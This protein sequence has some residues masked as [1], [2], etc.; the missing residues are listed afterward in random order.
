MLIDLRDRLAWPEPA[1]GAAA[2]LA[3]RGRDA[4]GRRCVVRRRLHRRGQDRARHPARGRRGRRV[5]QGTQRRHPGAAAVGCLRWAA[6]V[7]A[8]RP[9]PRRGQ[10]VPAAAGVE[11]GLRDRRPSGA[12][13]AHAATTRCAPPATRRPCSST[14]ARAAGARTGPRVRCSAWCRRRVHASTRAG[15]SPA[16]PCC[17]TPTGWSRRRPA[18]SPT[19]S[20]SCSARRR[21]WCST[22][23]RAAPTGWCN[24]VD[25]KSDD[26]ALFLLHRR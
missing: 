3:R 18:T 24:S 4:L 25:S 16:T 5:R 20:T 8:A 10:P 1:A 2:R 23:S 7:A 9:V 13:P 12:R 14:P 6:R 26:R 19:A 17:S 22:A 15:C 21:S 11:R